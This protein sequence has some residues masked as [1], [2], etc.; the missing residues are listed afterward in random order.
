M[1][2]PPERTCIAEQ[3]IGQHMAE[4]KCQR[5]CTGPADK[6]GYPTLWLRTDTA[7]GGVEN[8]GCLE[9]L[10]LHRQPALSAAPPSPGPGSPIELSNRKGWKQTFLDAPMRQAIA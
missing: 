3:Q 7:A 8:A 1:Q 9:S 10:Y 4:Q 5:Q 6:M 2:S